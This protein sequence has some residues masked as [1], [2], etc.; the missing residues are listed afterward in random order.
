VIDSVRWLHP[1]VDESWKEHAACIG[2]DP[3]LWFPNDEGRRHYDRRVRALT[4]T[5]RAICARCPV[6]ID[7]LQYAI[8][9][10]ARF[11]MFG[12]LTEW[13]RTKITKRRPE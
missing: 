8:D 7:C 5:A 2:E 9:V 10:D 6:R 3:R 4:M 11:G 12:G 1:A 13:E